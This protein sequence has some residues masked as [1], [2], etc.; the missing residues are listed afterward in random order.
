MRNEGTGKEYYRDIISF[1]DAVFEKDINSITFDDIKEIGR[2][3]IISFQRSEIEKGFSNKS[4]NRKISTVKRFLMYLEGEGYIGGTSYFNNVNSLPTNNRNRYGAFTMD[5][6]YRAADLIME[7]EKEFKLVKK[8]LILLSVDTGLR[9]DALLNLKWTDFEEK[10]ETVQIKHVDKGNKDYRPHIEKW[11]YEE[12]LEIKEEDK[13]YVFNI[14]SSTIQGM[15]NRLKTWMD[16]PKERNIVFH[17]FRKAGVT[18]VYKMTGDLIAAQKFAN[19][20]SPD[21]TTLYIETDS[22]GA[23]GA[24]SNGGNID[25]ELYKKVDDDMLRQAIES[26]TKDEIYRLNIRI[27]KIME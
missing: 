7:K 8:H 5:E 23:I 19:H 25:Q 21:T 12:L 18:H 11:R 10:E 6:V 1:M 9:K 2:E 15:M 14:S 17:S 27:G 24:I 16:I 13:E 4:I 3:D 22:L 26:M 20:S